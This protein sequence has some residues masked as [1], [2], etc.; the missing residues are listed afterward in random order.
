MMK[1]QCQ[2]CHAA[3]GETCD[4]DDCRAME[5]DYE[6]LCEAMERARIAEEHRRLT[7]D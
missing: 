1:R 7:R 3:I 4:H 6:R 5:A 2:H